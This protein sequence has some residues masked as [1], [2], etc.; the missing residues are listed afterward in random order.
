MQRF[1][2]SQREEFKLFRKLDSPAKIQDFLDSM[3]I[4]FELKRETCRSPLM[5]LKHNEAHCME[6]A[7]LA[8]AVLWYHG[9]KP[10]LL[11][12]KANNN[13]DDHVVALFRQ[14]NL[15]GAISKTN[16]AVLQYRDPIYKTIRE[17]VLS[18]FN[19]YFLENGEKTLRWYSVPFDLLG[20]QGDWLA[21]RHNLWHLAADLDTSPHVAILD[22]GAARRLRKANALEIQASKLAQWEKALKIARPPHAHE[23][24][25]SGEIKI[26]LE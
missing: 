19:E 26:I 23:L 7:M 20:Y 21:S 3:R 18:Y 9:E 22:N 10:L 11:D 2:N 24:K 14:G 15:W 17:L 13:D 8:A 4:N 16:H 1:P 12:L 6:G 25:Q 5:A